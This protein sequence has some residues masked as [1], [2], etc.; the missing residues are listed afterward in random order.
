MRPSIHLPFPTFNFLRNQILIS[1][2]SLNNDYISSLSSASVDAARYLKNQLMLTEQT[3]PFQY[4][5]YILFSIT[6]SVVSHVKMQMKA[7]QIQMD[8]AWQGQE[9]YI[10]ASNYKLLNST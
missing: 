9:K 5:Y 3:L 7:P 8:Y 1:K 2:R 10:S 6:I 4:R